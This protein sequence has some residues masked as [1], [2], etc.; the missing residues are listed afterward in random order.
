ML[1]SQAGTVSGTGPQTELS[2]LHEIQSLQ[3]CGKTVN[4]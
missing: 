1:D 3:V 2:R 4:C